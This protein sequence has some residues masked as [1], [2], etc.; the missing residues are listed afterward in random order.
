MTKGN[1][2]RMKETFGLIVTSRSFFPAHLI[3][4]ARDSVLGL[5]D[6][7]GYGCISV[8]EDSCRMGAVQTHEEALTCAELFSR[9]RELISG[10]IVVLPNFGEESAVADAIKLSG[11]SVPVLVQACDDDFDKLD[12]AHRRDAFCGKLSVCNNLYQ[13]GIPFTDTSTHTCRID[14]PEFRADIERFAA[15]CRVTKALRSARIA[16][17]GVRP[18]AFRTVRFSEKLL[19]RAGVDVETVD[20]S[21]VIHR[22]EAIRD[23]ALIDKKAAEIRAYGAVPPYIG[24]EKVEKQARLCLAVQ[25]LVEELDCD[26]SAV[27]CWDALENYYGCAACLAMSMM[28]EAGKPSACESDVMGALTMLAMDRAA[29]SAPAYMDW[30]NNIREERDKCLSQHCSNFPRSFF[31]APVEIENLDVLSSTLG[32]E[33]CFGCCKGQVAAGPMTFAKLSTDDFTGRICAYVGEGEFLD[34]PMPTK[35]GLACCRIENLQGLMKY[36]CSNGFEHHV[37]F[38]RGHV[39][40]VLCEAFGKYLGYSVYRHV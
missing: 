23:A 17:L 39:A 8:D 34:E 22:A 25:Q 30:N 19:Q 14:S 4:E 18:S 11:L 21:T 5:L 33:N 27:Q 7:M 13:L 16:L 24:P 28:G 37:A 12:M 40:D 38:V 35:G 3:K 29:G 10:I 6:S 32:A 20:M 2:I 31:G 26:A 36:I 15:V 1:H 9:N